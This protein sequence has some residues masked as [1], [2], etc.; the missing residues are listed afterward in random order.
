MASEDQRRPITIGKVNINDIGITSNSPNTTSVTRFQ[1]A[2]FRNSSCSTPPPSVV[3]STMANSHKNLATNLGNMNLFPCSNPIRANPKQIANAGLYYLGVRDRAKCWYCNGGLQNWERD[4]DPW[5]EHAKCEFVLQQKGP[6]YVHGIVFR[7]PNL[8]RPTI[9]NPANPNQLRNIQ[10]GPI[11]QNGHRNGGPEI[12]DP[13]EEV[14]SLE[15]KADGEMSSSELVEQAKL[16]RF[17]ERMIKTA[18]KWKYETTGNGFSRLEIFVESILAME[19]EFASN[20]SKDEGSASATKKE[21][22][23]TSFSNMSTTSELQEIRRLQEERMCKICGNEQASVV[24]IPCGHIACCVGCA[25]NA[26]ICPICCL[27]VR[28]KVRSFIV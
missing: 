16:I 18:F 2:I 22:P 8:R 27:R 24:L 20:R 11:L 5:E 4:D 10:S 1:T 17:D 15:R 13:R 14:R 23:S 19:E 3:A 12:I 26:S 21:T 6:D 28:E 9:Q 7:I 25:E